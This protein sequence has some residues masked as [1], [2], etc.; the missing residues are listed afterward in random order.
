MTNTQTILIVDDDL[1]ILEV[2]DAR[3]SS[4][5][6]KPLKASCAS[7]ALEILKSRHVDLM[8]S[9]MKMPGMGG[10]SLLSQAKEIL[11]TLPVII[12]T[13]YGTIPDAVR[14]VKAGAVEYLTKPFDGRDLI[15][16][17]REI[18]KQ[19]L[20]SLNKTLPGNQTFYVGES[21][22]M[23]EL[24]ALVERVA[25]S[26]VNVLLLGESGVGKECIANLVHSLGPRK[27]HPFAVVDCGST[28][29]GLLESELFGHLRGAFTHAIRDKKGLI[30]MADQGTL[31]LDEIGNI[32]PEMQVR[33]LRFLEDRKIRK[34][35]DLK[36]IPVN[37]RVI[38]ATNANLVEE[39][40][41][42]RF[43]EDLY[44]RL[45]VVTLKIPPLR[46]RKED[47]PVLVENFV[48]LFCKNNKLPKVKLPPKTLQWLCNY[49]WPG[50]VREIRNAL[51]AG[52]ILCKN[53]IMHPEDLH[54]TG[55]PELTE[56][57]PETDSFSLEESERKAII[58][59]LQQAGGIQKDAAELLGISRRAIHYKIK[60]YE[61]DLSDMRPKRNSNF[62]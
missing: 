27:D 13:A 35:G 17:I 49:P 20:P 32:S 46:E 54:L 41:S 28:P 3:L 59:A 33:L 47:I 48:E 31:F 23:K 52:V 6:Y 24:Y 58:R 7:E 39:I 18:L 43:R 16:K 29:T 4:S 2:M 61:I 26:D 53:G 11:P 56:N 19:N 9:D 1:H 21:P 50:N 45:R 44:Y 62:F 36:E 60:K 51:E 34:I 10:M 42:G 22:A 55:L 38:A 12:L 15:K 37:C 5:G 14:A 25:A 57:A 8:I 40:K 30:E